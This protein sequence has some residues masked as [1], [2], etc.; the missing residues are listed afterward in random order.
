MATLARGTA[1]YLVGH[2]KSARQYCEQAEAIFRDRCTGVAWE[3]DTVQAFGLWALS[4]LGET[5]ELSRRWPILLKE[6]RE[7]G[8][9]YAVMNLSTYLMSIVRLAAGAPDEARDE[10][11]RTM[12][13]WS[14]EGYH[15]QHN[16]C[17]VG[18]VAGRAVPGRRPRG[19]GPPGTVLARAVAVVAAPGPV[20]PDLDVVAPGPDRPRGG[21]DR[22]RPPAVPAPGGARR[23]AG[24]NASDCP[25]PRRAPR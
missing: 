8:D 11:R 7:R 9:L 23:R 25:T 15:V 14:R 20:H 24:S 5:A 1:D 2:W 4:H 17:A 3:L 22:G 21:D 6:A 18:G 16:D 10:L 13:Q 12:A 19:L